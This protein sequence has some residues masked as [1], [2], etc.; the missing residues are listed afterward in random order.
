MALLT[1]GFA[2]CVCQNFTNCRF[3]MAFLCCQALAQDAGAH[4]QCASQA[5]KFF[6]RPLSLLSE[7]FDVLSMF[8]SLALLPGTYW[9]SHAMKGTLFA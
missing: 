3:L 9:M 4:G 6:G 2:Q 1:A 7:L 5:L 8:W